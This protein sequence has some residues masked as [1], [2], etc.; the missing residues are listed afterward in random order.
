MEA[1]EA[2]ATLKCDGRTWAVASVHGE[3]SR[4]KAINKAIVEHFKPGDNLVYLGNMI[5]RGS[6]V[7]ETIDELLLTRRHLM[8]ANGAESSNIVFLRGG[9]EEMWQKLLTLQFAGSPKDVLSWMIG[10]GVDATLAAYGS[11]AQEGMAAAEDGV[12]GLTQW[13]SSL[14]AALRKHD[15]HTALLSS[16]KRAA[17][18]ENSALLFVNTGIDVLRSLNEQEDTFWWGG[19]DFNAIQSPYGKFRMIV[20]GYDSK[21][22]GF[23]FTHHTATLD[24][25]CGSGGPLEAVCF[26]PDGTV[27]ERFEA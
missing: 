10:H 12:M 15:G 26:N 4:L 7:A 2:F 13:T 14:R 23:R 3:A 6:A 20:R 22:G 1:D 5:G 18:F 19:G 21:K 16:L 27:A 24:N 25:K 9:Q 8:A 11:S 17:F